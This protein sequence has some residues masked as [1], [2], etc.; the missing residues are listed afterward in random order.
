MIRGVAFVLVVVVGGLAAR[1][2]LEIPSVVVPPRGQLVLHDVTLIQP[3]SGH[4]AHADVWVLGDRIEKI[5][6][7]ASSPRASGSPYEGS[8]VTPGLID[9]HFHVPPWW[10]PGQAEL[11]NLLLLLHGVTT[12]RDMG[13]IDGRV[14]ELRESIRRGERAGPR[15]FACGQPLDGEPPTWPFAR[16]I[17]TESEAEQAV[18]DLVASGADCIKVYSRIAPSVLSALQRSAQ[19]G[20]VPL[21][22]HLPESSPWTEDRVGDLQHL[23]D[24]RC[25][26]MSDANADDLVRTAM[27]S[28]LAHTP[29]LVVFAMQLEMYDYET[30][31]ARPS[32]ALLP[33]FWLEV[34]W[35]PRYRLGFEAPTG[36]VAEQ[37][38]RHEVLFR[39]LLETV[40]QM[41]RQGVR[42]HAGTDPPNPLVIPGASLHEELRLLVRA[43]LTIEE[44]WVAATATA[45]ESLAE[46]GLGTVSE[47]APADL[48]IFERDPTTDLDSLSTLEAVVADGR[49]FR[50]E[51]LERDLALQ[52]QRFE[53]P[54][55]DGVSRWVA[56][57]T[58]EAVRRFDAHP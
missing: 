4:L 15:I 25:W 11:F 14:F 40:R 2:C 45:G 55:F 33:R 9:M 5:E 30:A 49:L 53:D 52:R 23:C 8:F 16:V 58:A 46:P 57:V 7:S 56:Y 32:V 13:T 34:L 18:I 50:K 20:G 12:V 37:R 24:P 3:G 19:S 47:G 1:R 31:R 39:R 22:G 29:T 42:L 17:R 54:I 27:V 21:V 44:A 10:A 28:H 38:T 43:G 26:T 6:R 48:L 35:N 36:E 51:A 41:H